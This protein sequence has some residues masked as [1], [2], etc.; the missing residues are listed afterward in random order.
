MRQT[1]F[2]RRERIGSRRHRATIRQHNGNQDDHGRPTHEVDE[3]WDIIVD[4]WPVELITTG[5]E[6]IVRGTRVASESTH[7]LYGEYQAAKG[8]TTDMEAVINSVTYDIIAAY[9][10]DGDGREMRVEMKLER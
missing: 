1:S 9:D 8:I 6:E 2:G 3:D 10:S 5:G 7:V 4:Q